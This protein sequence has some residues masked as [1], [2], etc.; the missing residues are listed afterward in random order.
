MAYM[1]EM[2]QRRGR[3]AAALGFL[4]VGITFAQATDGCFP[5]GYGTKQRGMA[6]AGIALPQDSFI[7]ANN[8][9]GLAWVG[10]R[11]DIAVG[12]FNPMRKYTAGPNTLPGGF[13]PGAVQSD[14]EYFLVPSIGATWTQKD[15][16]ALG[17][18][19]FINGGLNTSYREDA[20]LGTG[21]F[22]AGPTGINIE[23]LF[24]SGTYARKLGDKASVGL[25]TMFV[26]QKLTASGMGAFVGYVPHAAPY[27]LSDQGESVSTGFG[28]RLGAQTEIAPKL[29]LAASYQPKIKMTKFH[30]YSDLLADHGNFDIPENY[31]VGLALKT[32]PTSALCFDVRQINYSGVPSLGNPASNLSNGL[33][34]TDGPGF[35]WRDMTVYKVGYQWQATDKWTGR[36]GVSYGRQPVPS[37]EVFFNIL[38]PAVQ[39]WHFAL[40]ATK[41]ITPSSEFSISAFY[42]PS[43]TVT[44]VHPLKPTQTISIEM[45]QVEIE[46]GY[47]KKF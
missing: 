7:V 24:V 37:K 20:N 19:T 15:G 40:G 30:D 3:L 34:S 1:H 16:S 32:S 14:T 45:H 10:R 23:Q 17:L 21:T 12:L 26:M 41:K 29:T 35:G 18:A 9:A 38:A 28:V 33:G 43:K 27:H 4:A 8:P 6:G 39:E 47:S 13:V 25:S 44:G 22:G 5:V 42:A 46:I 2:D 31:T 36:A 11:F